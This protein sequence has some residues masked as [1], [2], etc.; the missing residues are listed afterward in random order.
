MLGLECESAAQRVCIRRL[1][2]RDM[3]WVE[4]FTEPPSVTLLRAEVKEVSGA[5]TLVRL[6]RKSMLA[7]CGGL[8]R[9]AS[10]QG[11]DNIQRQMTRLIV[12]R[13]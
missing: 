1:P 13:I 6:G 8:P 4:N 3:F 11:H 12:S 2:S 9:N 10:N 5:L 7:R